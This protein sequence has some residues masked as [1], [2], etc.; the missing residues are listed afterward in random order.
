MSTDVDTQT[1]AEFGERVPEGDS[2]AEF[3]GRV[4]E[5]ETQFGGRVPEGEAEFGGRVPE[6]EAEFGGRVPESEA[7]FGGMCRK[8]R[9][10]WR[11]GAGNQSFERG[12]DQHVSFGRNDVFDG[13]GALVDKGVEGILGDL[14]VHLPSLP[15][16]AKAHAVAVGNQ[17]EGV[18]V[19]PPCKQL[20]SP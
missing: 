6:G 8:A 19:R 2:E 20:T 16:V 7:E 12:T 17:L 13:V 9:Q 11:K 14:T 18:K 5:S 4:P 10:I 1:M 3:E 15:V